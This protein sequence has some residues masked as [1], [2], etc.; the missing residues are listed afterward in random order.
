MSSSDDVRETTDWLARTQDLLRQY[1]PDLSTAGWWET[2]APS[3]SLSLRAIHSQ[4]PSDVIS[5]YQPLMPAFRAW[6][7]RPD[8]RPRASLARSSLELDAHMPELSNLWAELR[9]ALAG[10]DDLLATFLTCWDPPAITHNCSSV[11]IPGKDPMLARNYDYDPSLIDGVV[12]DSSWLGRR[13]L[14]T[15]D[16]VWGLLDGVNDA[17]LAVGFTYGGRPEVG[18]G[19]GIPLVIR[20]LLQTC[21]DVCGAI[22]TLQRLPIHVSYNISVVDASGD[23][24]TVF[25]RPTGKPMVTRDLVTTN[26]QEHVHWPEHAARFTSVERADRLT[27]VVQ[28]G[29]NAETVVEAM[30]QDPVRVSRFGE[31][32]G[33]IYTAVYRPTSRAVSYRWPELSWSLNLGQVADEDREIQLAEGVTTRWDAWQR[34]VQE[35]S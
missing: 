33:T 21:D 2:T 5:I 7:S 3:T 32:F 1:A 30:L 34:W 24:A 19:F 28:A 14:G 4:T 18:E 9:G 11:I 13:V 15:A 35:A 25:V 29:A 26:H 16:Q 8:A 23:H 27:N 20:Y 6:F 17:G 31:G 22:N 10:D 12:I